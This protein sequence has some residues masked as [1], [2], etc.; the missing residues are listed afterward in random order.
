MY[1]I[2]N[3]L[4][5]GHNLHDFNIE[6]WHNNAVMICAVVGSALRDGETRNFSCPKETFGRFIAIRRNIDTTY[7]M[8]LC[9]VEVY[10]Q[11]SK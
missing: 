9:E 10:G 8:Q 2:Y 3:V 5:T 7:T 1:F 11:E 4:Q 6:A